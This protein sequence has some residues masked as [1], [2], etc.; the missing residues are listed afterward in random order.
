M[1]DIRNADNAERL[2]SGKLGE[3]LLVVAHRGVDRVEPL[4]GVGGVGGQVA[5]NRADHVAAR[6]LLVL[7]REG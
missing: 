3:H 4:G 6:V 7:P 2:A 5:Q 1:P